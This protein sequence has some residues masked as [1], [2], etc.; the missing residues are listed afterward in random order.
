MKPFHILITSA[1]LL[2]INLAHAE[3]VELAPTPSFYTS[4]FEEELTLFEDEI[5]E[6]EEEILALEEEL[7]NDAAEFEESIALETQTEEI[8][9]EIKEDPT[10]IA[11]AD[12]N[13]LDDFPF[14]DNSVADSSDLTGYDEIEEAVTLEPEAPEIV[15]TQSEIAL[16][17]EPLEAAVP[18]PQVE[19]TEL[20]RATIGGE[21]P[22]TLQVEKTSGRQDAIEVNLEQAFAGSPYIY[23]LL[24]LMSVTAIGIWSYSL[25]S[26]NSYGKPSQ[27]FV[28]TLQNKLM[29]NQF[30]EALSLCSLHENVFSKMV[31][32][33][34]HSRRHGL[35]IMVESMKA[36]GKRASVHFWQRIGLLNDIAILA[37]M[38]G[39]LGTVLGMFYA[40]YDINRS[41][42]S[43]S[44]LF[45]GLGVSV[46]TTVAG[47]SVAILAL[48]LHSTAKYRLVRTLAY[49]EN[50]GMSLATL[51]DDRT[52]V[53]KA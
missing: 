24:G 46:G 44:T 41:I 52:S 20:D 12:Q 6:F 18:T 42:E 30:D 49:V 29:S 36:E 17:S 28:K 34:I 13:D 8:A 3:P 38:L 15:D 40:F 31:A 9:E 16:E 45:D 7:Q 32:T 25:L 51:I 33:G 35:P 43:I 39:L 47:I 23:T 48:I 4:E 5:D 21:A 19:L 2:S 37:P 50:E 26:L 53:S 10:P 22:A 14:V 27:M 11:G 1:C